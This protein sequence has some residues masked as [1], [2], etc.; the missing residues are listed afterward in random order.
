[1][2]E[3]KLP[4]SEIMMM[5][6]AFFN[7]GYKLAGE[8]LS[9]DSSP[10]L[11]MRAMKQFYEVLDGFIDM[12][13]Q[14][15]SSESPVHCEKGCDFCCHQAVF[16]ES[17]EFRYLKDWLFQ[18]MSSEELQKIRERAKLKKERTA[19]LAPEKL[20]EHKEACPLLVN[21]SCSAYEARPVACRI[22][23]SM[24]RKSCEEEMLHPENKAKFP[25]LFDLPLKLGKR[26]NQGFSLRLKELGF[27]IQ[28]LPVEVGLLK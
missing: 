16:A 4:P 6:Q 22:Y 23:L 20:L 2:T 5:E 1:M 7:D 27:D 25:Q 12:F 13:V 28:E 24:N 8:F 21:R 14:S 11:L 17:H 26:F 15:T 9:E 19:V 10:P 18:N 3:K